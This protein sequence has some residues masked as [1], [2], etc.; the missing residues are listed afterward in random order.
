MEDYSWMPRADEPLGEY[1][2]SDRYKKS[3]GVIFF[4]NFEEQEEANYAFWRRLTPFQRLEL[5]KIMLDSIYASV[6]VKNNFNEP[7]D[8]VF[9]QESS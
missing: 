9:T 8:I 6:L 2:Q 1:L 7:L 3:A 5:H 4:S